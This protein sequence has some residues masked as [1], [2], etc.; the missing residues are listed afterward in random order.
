MHLEESW[1]ARGGGGRGEKRKEAPGAKRDIKGQAR[2]LG[3]SGNEHT[4]EPSRAGVSVAVAGQETR[5]EEGREGG[6]VEKKE[7]ERKRESAEALDGNGGKERQFS[8][9]EQSKVLAEGGGGFAF[10]SP[11]LSPPP[12]Q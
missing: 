12:P 11:H 7:K 1:P 9:N 5:R 4:A 6:K 8:C 2:D 10:L 3:E